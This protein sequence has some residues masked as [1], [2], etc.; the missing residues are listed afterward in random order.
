MT[1]RFMQMSR[2]LSK[3]E[4]MAA[5]SRTWFRLSPQFLQ[6]LR[7]SDGK[8]FHTG[9]R[10]LQ[11]KPSNGAAS[12]YHMA[13]TEALPEYKH[14]AKIIDGVAMAKE[15]REEVRV[16]VDQWVAK[17]HR[18]P[19]LSVVLVGDNPASASYVKAKTRAA[20]GAGITSETI[21]KPSSI[22]EEEL[23]DLV[24]KLNKDD[25]VDGLL[26]QLP[27][28][29]HMTERTICNA[30]APE[31]DV[32]GFNVVNVGRF[33]LDEPAFL[34][35]TPYGVMEM[36]RRT[37]IET[38]GKNAVVCGRSKNV[39]MPLAMLLHTDKEHHEICADATTTICHRYTP[40]DQLEVF[41]K[42]ADI[43]IVAVGMPNLITADMVKE[44]VVVIDVGIN[45]VMDP[46]TGKMKLVG[47]VD[48]EGVSQKASYI[49]PVPGG[50]GPMT[51]A[52][53]MKNT[54]QAAK[55]QYSWD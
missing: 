36:I 43:I 54:M 28:P 37:G 39:G 55:G 16:E 41:T 19:H 23:L 7:R 42:T 6:S 9:R 44:G 45:R 50:V 15:I 25:S 31:K 38:F 46:V 47:D 26:V 34:P 21:V 17:G 33:C 10:R 22:T 13:N 32:D 2:L 14:Q 1:P 12:V 49:T 51:V 27:V 40:G 52:M 20:K 24:D 4:K 5:A 11:T 8:L 53:L 30:V 48:F 29:D 18:A 3:S 35:A